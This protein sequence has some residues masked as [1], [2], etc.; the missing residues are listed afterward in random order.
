V[1]TGK[2]RIGISRY[3]KK[4]FHTSLVQVLDWSLAGMKQSIIYVIKTGIKW[5]QD[6]YS[7]LRSWLPS[8][9]RYKVGNITSQFVTSWQGPSNQCWSGVYRVIDWYNT[10]SIKCKTSLRRAEANT[11]LYICHISAKK[12]WIW[13]QDQ[14]SMLKGQIFFAFNFQLST[15]DQHWLI[16]DTSASLFTYQT[17]AGI[18]VHLLT[19]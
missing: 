6:R 13:Y 15:P 3:I 14:L 1:Q 9:Y 7:Y 12:S 10:C 11:S 2:E 16:V 8:W 5:V 4:N 17:T 18:F 19:K